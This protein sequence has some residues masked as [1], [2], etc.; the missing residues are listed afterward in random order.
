M[1]YCVYII[2]FICGLVVRVIWKLSKVIYFVVVFFYKNVNNV[3]W[4]KFCVGFM[5]GV[6]EVWRSKNLEY[7]MFYFVKL[8]F[9]VVSF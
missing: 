6:V 8:F 1:E 4:C 9:S 5:Y 2:M 3:E 7:N